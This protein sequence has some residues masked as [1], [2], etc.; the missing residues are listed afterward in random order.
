MQRAIVTIRR[1]GWIDCLLVCSFLRG[2]LLLFFLHH[3]M[4]G[5]A[6]L[7]RQGS[8]GPMLAALIFGNWQQTCLG[9]MAGQ[10]GRRQC[11]HR[12]ASGTT[13]NLAVLA[14][15]MLL[16]TLMGRSMRMR[17]RLADE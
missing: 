15:T 14:V 10:I 5:D 4:A 6:S 9:R 16:A 1:S 13:L 2:V 17:M 8:A 12:R 3:G 11:Q 7:G